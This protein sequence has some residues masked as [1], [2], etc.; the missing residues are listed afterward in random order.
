M[1]IGIDDT[2][3][4]K[5]MCTTYLCA[6]LVSEFREAGL[7]VSLPYLVRLNPCIPQK[8]RGNGAV[9]IDVSALGRANW[10]KYVKERVISRIKELAFVED[11][12]THPGAVFA[13]DAALEEIRNDGKKSEKLLRF[14]ERAVKSVLKLEDALCLISELNLEYFK[15]KSGRGLIGA[16]AAVSFAFAHEL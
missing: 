7:S 12:N 6:V 5:G 10:E 4:R 15:M 3:A 8:T 13:Y 9:C 11:E 14:Y 16:L 1:L 2:D